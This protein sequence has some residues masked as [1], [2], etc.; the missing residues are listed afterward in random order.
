MGTTTRV[1]A[2]VRYVATTKK[3]ILDPATN[4]SSG[5][6]YKVTVTTGAQDFSRQLA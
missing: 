5:R 1:T 6:T 4:V 3:A 2:A